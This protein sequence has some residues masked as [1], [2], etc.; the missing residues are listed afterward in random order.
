MDPFE[1]R[2]QFISL[3]KKLNAS[4]QSI[5]KIVGYALKLWDCIVEE[6][7][8]G[9][10][11]NRINILYLLD[12]LSEASLLAKSH[13][14]SVSHD[15]NQQHASY[16]VDYVARDLGQIVE[17]VVPEGRQ[18]LPNLMS[19]KQILENWRSKRVLDPQKVDDA[20]A[21]LDSRRE[22]LEQDQEQQSTEP[23]KPTT[24]LPRQ[25]IFKRIEE[26]RER[27]KRL[28]E[29]RWVQPV[30]HN[31]HT[32]LPPQLACFLPLTDDGDGEGELTLDIEFENDWEATSDWNED[33]DEAAV[34]ENQLCFPNEDGE[35]MDLS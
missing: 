35:P 4:Q 31:P 6:C 17:Y 2:L 5:Q 12:S 16:Y 29:R 15:P 30:A 34:E 21:T 23:S 18:G 33:D 14:G 25:E 28:R 20:L 1:V 26:D 10:I 9:S 13:P 27:H 22:A 3:L 8:K 32:H 11:N 19:T 7:Q 24:A